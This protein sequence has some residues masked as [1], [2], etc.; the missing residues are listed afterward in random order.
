MTRS[1]ERAESPLREYKKMGSGGV[2]PRSPSI[3]ETDQKRNFN[4]NCKFRAPCELCIRPK[5][6]PK[7]SLGELRMGV[8][9]KLIASARNSSRVLS[10]N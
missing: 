7:L 3:A 2:L 8:F 10:V 4:A 9:V 5:V 1:G 6:L